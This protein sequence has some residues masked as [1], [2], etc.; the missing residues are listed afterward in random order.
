MFRS[1]LSGSCLAAALLWGAPAVHADGIEYVDLAGAR[2]VDLSVS[3]SGACAVTENGRLLC[4]GDNSRGQ[5]GLDKQNDRLPPTLRSDVTD[6]LR[7]F[8]ADTGG[9]AK[10]RSGAIT[11]W[12]MKPGS[13]VER[14]LGG[15]LNQPLAATADWS[16]G[17]CRRSRLW[18]RQFF[19]R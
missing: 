15:G 18:G 5:L 17:K 6:A 14:F 1:V 16:T 7:V 9:C 4:W 8:L 3:G 2:A 10:Q 11:C 19:R 12:G 13:A